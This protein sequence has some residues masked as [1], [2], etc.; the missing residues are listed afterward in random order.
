MRRRGLKIGAA[1]GVLVLGAV[2]LLRFR[3]APSGDLAQLRRSGVLRIGT[4]DDYAPFVELTRGGRGGL[5]TELAERMARDLGV[6][7]V[8][9]HFAWSHLANDLAHHRFDLVASGVTVRADRALTGRFT[10]PY[11]LTGAVGLIRS[12]DANRFGELGSLDRPEVR[13]QVNRGGHLEQVAR[14]RFPHAAIEPLA[15]NHA[16]TQDVLGGKADVAVSD[17][18]E[19]RALSVPGLSV[20]GPF[21]HDRKALWVGANAPELVAW[22]DGW[23]V[24]RERDGWLGELRRRHLG[25]ETSATALDAEAVLSSV[26]LR[27]GLMPLVAQVKARLGKPILDPAQ[28]ARVLARSAD[29]AKA[30]GL[31]PESVRALYG[32]LMAGARE[33]ETA[34]PG[35]PDAALPTLDALRAAIASIDLELIASLRVA[36]ESDPHRDWTPLVEQDL[37]VDGLRNE[38]RT[39]LARA[40]GAVRVIH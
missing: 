27:F 18:A 9:V 5:D 25:S 19:A 23:L 36:C 13:I 4:S 16:L 7:A 33:V 38:S 26:E 37:S 15:D 3:S 34:R 22:A 14:A 6:K 20:I 10:R 35:G 30:Q 11:A 24:A 31:D 29:T 8:W 21:T 40:L 1:I 32:V 28:E 17:S 12:A 39:A 2:L